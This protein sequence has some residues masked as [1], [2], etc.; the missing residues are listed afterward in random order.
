MSEIHRVGDLEDAQRLADPAD[1]PRV[2]V[3]VV[4]HVPDEDVERRERN[5]GRV[6]SRPPSLAAGHASAAGGGGGSTGAA[7]N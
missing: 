6:L 5:L 2:V 4:Q 7:A 1:D 3:V